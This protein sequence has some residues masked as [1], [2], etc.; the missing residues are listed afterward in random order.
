MAD[1]PWVPEYEGVRY[2]GPAVD[3]AGRLHKYEL[4]VGAAK[5]LTELLGEYAF[6]TPAPLYLY[7][8]FVDAPLI[9]F[10][11][12]TP[13]ARF[14]YKKFRRPI[15]RGLEAPSNG[16]PDWN[17]V[18]WAVRVQHWDAFADFL[19][20]ITLTYEDHRDVAGVGQQTLDVLDPL[21]TDLATVYSS[22]IPLVPVHAFGING[23]R[24]R[25]GLKAGRSPLMDP[26][27][28]RAYG[29]DDA[30]RVFAK[31]LYGGDN[32]LN[33]R[34]YHNWLKSVREDDK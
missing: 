23:S 4:K 6:F 26:P 16:N 17:F 1:A 29:P 21:A 14:Y 5:G 8:R 32:P 31:A 7:G 12:A 30:M 33:A 24:F 3:E 11:H 25:V 27:A 34:A 10:A 19:V 9:D 20:S 18:L 28:V 15:F 2:G 22:A 13:D